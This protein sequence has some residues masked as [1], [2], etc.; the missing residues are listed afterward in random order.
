MLVRSSTSVSTIVVF[1]TGCNSYNKCKEK[2]Y[3]SRHK[4]SKIATI[5]ARYCR[6]DDRSMPELLK[7][8]YSKFVIIY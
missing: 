5:I 2:D 4:R 1:Y 8:K 7:T 6:K 3:I